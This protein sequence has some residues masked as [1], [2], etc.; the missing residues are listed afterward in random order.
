MI[1]N[2]NAM[3]ETLDV[4]SIDFAKLCKMHFNFETTSIQDFKDLLDKHISKGLDDFAT[5]NIINCLTYELLDRQLR[6]NALREIK[7]SFIEKAEEL[8]KKSVD[9]LKEFLEL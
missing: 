7:Y 9:E 3:I 6:L 8:V 5:I 2:Q 4:T 1:R